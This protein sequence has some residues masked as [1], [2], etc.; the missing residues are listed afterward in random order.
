[1]RA[2]S[3]KNVWDILEQEF[4][5]NNKAKVIKLQTLRKEIENLKIKESESFKE[6]FSRVI[7][8]VNH[9]RTLGE[10]VIDQKVIQKK[11]LLAC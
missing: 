9:M 8:V 1:M 11:F 7:E 3:V 2:T 4:E 6:Y 10:D 5:G